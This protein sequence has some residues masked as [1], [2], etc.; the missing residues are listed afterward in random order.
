[1]PDRRRF[2]QRSALAASALVLPELPPPLDV[3][4]LGSHALLPHVPPAGP[5][6]PPVPTVD[7]NVL[8]AQVRPVIAAAEAL[9]LPL[10]TPT[11]RARP[12]MV[13]GALDRWCLV[14]VHINPETRVKVARGPLRPV[15][16]ER[17]WRA[18]LVKVRNEAGTTAAL[19]ATGARATHHWLEVS[20]F[21][22]PPM[23]ACL[24]GRELEYRI[25]RLYSHEAGR[26]E[27][28]LAFDVGQG[29]QDLG[30]RNEVPIL[31][32]CRA[33]WLPGQSRPAFPQP[34]SD[35]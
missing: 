10:E 9:G 24:S 21:D 30:F 34:G 1:M 8:L 33:D 19:R 35:R 3:G 13:Q 17:G 29:T 11:S 6:L 22:D 25:V 15:L 31:F 5:D 26:R 2:L 16:V 14:G 12:E 18:F 4:A 7:P 28:S 27:A 32:D 23:S 20:M